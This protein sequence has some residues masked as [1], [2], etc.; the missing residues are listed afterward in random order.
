MRSA[1][2][3]LLESE[4]AVVRAKYGLTIE[5]NIEALL[6]FAALRGELRHLQLD[7]FGDR[8]KMLTG[9]DSGTTCVWNGCDPYTTRAV[10]GVEGDGRR[11]NCGRTNKD[12][13]DFV[14]SATP[15]FERYLALY[16]T[17]Q[18]AGGCA[19]CRFFLMCKGQCPG[20]AIDGDWRNRT[21]HGD[22]WKAVYAEVERE[23]LDEG[24]APLSLSPRRA[25]VE[26][27]FLAEWARGRQASMANLLGTA[28]P[29][30]AGGRPDW[31]GACAAL[32]RRLEELRE[33]VG[34]EPGLAGG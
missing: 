5:E 15:G 10:R 1:R 22:V 23:L 18:S 26:A 32:R 8:R 19:G 13:V 25:A 31:R 29:P 14:K 9:D 6:G 17:P 2:L 4:S 24:Q 11:S 21:E 3:H 30:P 27:A 12:G 20:T 33:A 7:L 16:H 34:D 28:G